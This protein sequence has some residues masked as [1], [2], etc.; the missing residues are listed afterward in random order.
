MFNLDDEHAAKFEKVAAC[1]S[2]TYQEVLSALGFAH[3]SHEERGYF[4]YRFS[5]PSFVVVHALIRAVGGT[6]LADGGR[7]IDLCGGSGHLTRVLGGVSSLPPVLADLY[8]P[9]LWLARQF[10]VPGNDAVCCTANAP[11]PFARGAFRYAMC[12]DAF[13]FIWPKRQFV[14]EM[15]RLVDDR[16]GSGAVVISH[17]HNQLQWSPSHGQPLRPSGYRGLFETVEPRLFSERRLFDDVVNGGP[18]DLAQQDPAA[19]LDADPALVIVATGRSDV[20]RRHDLEPA[21]TATG[22]FRLN[23][24][25]QAEPHGDSVRLQLRFPSRAYEE[26]FGHCR[27]YMPESVTVPAAALAAL[28]QGRVPPELADLVRRRVILDLPPRYY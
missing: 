14:S 22:E 16:R 4:F 17:T 25:Y 15:L 6:V 8:F 27:A 12:A 19:A 23:P 7:A 3:G 9:K 28:R 10:T 20:F 24:L 1:E 13:M 18:I 11:L 21:G 2:A 5:D 26:E